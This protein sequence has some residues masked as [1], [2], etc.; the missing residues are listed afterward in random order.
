MD[1]AVEYVADADN[2]RVHP[3]VNDIHS[4]STTILVK[5]LIAQSQVVATRYSPH[6]SV[7]LLNKSTIIIYSATRL[8]PN[9]SVWCLQQSVEDLS[10]EGMLS[11][12]S[13]FGQLAIVSTR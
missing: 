4:Y 6:Y 1:V 11:S 7:I 13:R 5:T 10:L 3:H 12:A 8:P 2:V 9:T